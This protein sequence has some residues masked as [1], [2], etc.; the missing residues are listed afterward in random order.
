MTAPTCL[1]VFLKG[2]KRPETLHLQSHNQGRWALP[3]PLRRTSTPTP[4]KH[5]SLSPWPWPWDLYT[6]VF[7]NTEVAKREEVHTY[8]ALATYGSLAEPS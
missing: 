4:P 3:V 8:T 2:K 7:S 1:W 6:S 5:L